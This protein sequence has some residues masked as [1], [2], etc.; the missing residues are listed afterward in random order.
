MTCIH[1]IQLLRIHILHRFGSPANSVVTRFGISHWP[2][3]KHCPAARHIDPAITARANWAEDF[4]SSP[5]LLL[6]PIAITTHRSFSRTPCLESR[7]HARTLIFSVAISTPLGRGHRVP[8][9]ATIR[10]V[11]PSY[12][13]I[14]PKAL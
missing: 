10:R 4:F 13:Q 6:M 9:M 8:R 11:R 5:F 12:Q 1:I 7:H 2:P 3:T 14:H